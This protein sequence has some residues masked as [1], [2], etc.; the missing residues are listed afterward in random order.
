M[1]GAPE[2]GN[3]KPNLRISATTLVCFP[4]KEEAAPFR[5]VAARLPGVEVQ[6]TGIGR[7]NSLRAV[8]EAMD[9]LAPGLVLTCGFAGGLDPALASGMVLFETSEARLVEALEQAGARPARFHCAPRIAGTAAEKRSLREQTRADAVEMESATI[10]ALCRERGVACATV[11][12]VSDAAGEN[13][14]LDF[15]R[16]SRPDQSLDYAKLAWAIAKSPR[17]IGGLLRLQRQCRF[18]AERLA[19]VLETFLTSRGTQAGP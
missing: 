3:P 7:A 16:L 10:H 17:V 14:P 6:L 18:A 5:R 8:T 1:N 2:A 19:D 12:V 4:L 9:R 15:N 13:L 11:R